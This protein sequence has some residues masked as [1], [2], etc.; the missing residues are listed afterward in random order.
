MG[1]CGGRVR[2]TMSTAYHPQTDGG[3]E[4]L[5]Q[6]LE[7]F[8]RTFCGNHQNTW[9]QWLLLAEFCHNQRPHSTIGTSLF[10]ALMGY[11]PKGIILTKP[12]SDN[13]SVE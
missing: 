8:L 5:N 2:N 3:T 10:E 13:P 9:K 12:E 11:R 1:I 6:E 7:V 4:R